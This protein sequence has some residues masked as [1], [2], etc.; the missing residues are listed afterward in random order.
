MA[1]NV[2]LDGIIVVRDL[3]ALDGNSCKLTVKAIDLQLAW[4]HRRIKQGGRG[5][6]PTKLRDQA[7]KI[8]ALRCVVQEWMANDDNTSSS[9]ITDGNLEANVAV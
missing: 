2:I 5:L 7:A 1:Y 4:H 6:V 8:N 3:N 9:H